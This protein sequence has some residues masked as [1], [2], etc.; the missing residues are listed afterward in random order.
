V[1]K[2][3]FQYG[4]N[5]GYGG[6]EHVF[7]GLWQQLC[8]Q[9]KGKNGNQLVLNTQDIEIESIVFMSSSLQGLQD[10]HLAQNLV[11]KKITAQ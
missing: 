11:G 5:V 3:G 6:W 9:S 10:K 4:W 2:R 8:C 1:V 7:L